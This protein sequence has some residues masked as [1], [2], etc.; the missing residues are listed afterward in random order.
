MA[1]GLASAK[2]RG[3][4]HS[5]KKRDNP[6]PLYIQGF[7]AMGQSTPDVATDST[8]VTFNAYHAA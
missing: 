2:E 7:G 6:P 1:W 4:V 5:V 3:G 8:P